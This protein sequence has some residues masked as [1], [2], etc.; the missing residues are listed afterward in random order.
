MLRNCWYLQFL[1]VSL[2]LRVRCLENLKLS[3]SEGFSVSHS[4]NWIFLPKTYQALTRLT[5]MTIRWCVLLA[6]N[7]DF[8]KFILYCLVLIKNSSINPIRDSFHLKSVNI[9]LLFAYCIKVVGF[10]S[11]SVH[12]RAFLKDSGFHSLTKMGIEHELEHSRIPFSTAWN[13]TKILKSRTYSDY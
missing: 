6:R 2:L 9:S 12:E 11:F 3:L 13:Q 1:S 7:S 5:V 4:G 10:F 8:T